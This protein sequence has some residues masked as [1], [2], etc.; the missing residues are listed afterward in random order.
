MGKPK[1]FG[2]MKDFYSYLSKVRPD[3]SLGIALD[4]FF[5]L[6]Q[7]GI[8]SHTEEYSKQQAIAMAQWATLNDWTYLKSKDVWV[9]EEQEENLQELS[10]DQFH[11]LFIKST[12]P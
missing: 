12:Q 7:K 3:L 5:G 1:T 8:I 9:N 2:R 6:S 11:N 10:N 4:W